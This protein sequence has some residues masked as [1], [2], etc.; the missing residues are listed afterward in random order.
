MRAG[1]RRGAH[2]R[3]H[4]VPESGHRLRSGAGR[5][6]RAARPGAGSPQQPVCGHTSCGFRSTSRPRRRRL[7]AA[8]RATTRAA[9]VPS[10]T[11]TWCTTCSASRHGFRPATRSRSARRR[12]QR[13]VR[14]ATARLVE[15]IHA[16][17]KPRSGRDRGALAEGAAPRARLQPRLWCSRAPRTTSHISWSAPR[18]RWAISSGSASSSRRSRPRRRS[19]CATSRPSIRRWTL[20]GTSCSSTRKP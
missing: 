7:W 15:K 20:R 16:D 3:Q 5:G 4:E 1:G 9:R 17:C 11:A 18:G 14:P 12:M 19:A 6:D 13:R 8:W 2:H 10:A